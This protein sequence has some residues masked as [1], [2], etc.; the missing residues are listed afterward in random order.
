MNTTTFFTDAEKRRYARHFSLSDVGEE[1]QKKLKQARV[2]C[3]GAGGLG[4]PL[5]LYLAAAGVGNIGICDFDIVSESNLQR[6][7]LFSENDIGKSKAKIA[8]SRLM[9]LNPHI[10]YHVHE[11][12]LS[13][14]NALS[15]FENY[16]IIADGSDNF[17]TRYLVNDACLLTGKPCVFGAVSRFEG[18]VSVFNLKRAD[19]TFGPNYRDIFPA[20][21]AAGS[22][23][24]CAEAGV[25]GVLPGII[26]SMQANEVI[27]V[28]TGIGEP[29]DGRLFLFDATDLSSRT[30]K[31]RK[32]SAIKVEKLIDYDFF[33]GLKVPEISHEKLNKMRAKRETFQLID[34]REK[35][36]YE[37]EN[38]GGELMPLSELEQHFFK[39]S[40]DNKVII[41]CQTGKRSLVAVGKLL[42]EGFEKVY[43]LKGGMESSRTA[44]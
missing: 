31:I 21:P 16:D 42:E 10:N 20:A 41:H 27:K 40:R 17:P 12:K 19:A 25:L 30:L 9:D 4:S 13:S 7:I 23:L 32:N 37:L 2:L 33:C 44:S 11:E 29:L 36:E 26:G 22:V 38:M 43:S 15:I 18:Q 1:G 14:E 3:I 28:I 8:K 35:E 6:Q 5:L 39:I 24:N 34:V